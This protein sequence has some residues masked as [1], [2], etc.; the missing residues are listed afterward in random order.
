LAFFYD[1]KLVDISIRGIALL[2]NTIV[3][4]LVYVHHH[5]QLCGVIYSSITLAWL[6][7]TSNFDC[8]TGSLFHL[9]SICWLLLSAHQLFVESPKAAPMA[10]E[11]QWSEAAPTS[12]M[13][14]QSVPASTTDLAIIEQPVSAPAMS[15]AAAL[16]GK[17]VIDDKPF[18]SP[19]IKG[20]ALSI[21]ICQEEYRK[22]VEDCRKVLRARLTLNKGDKPY[23]ARDL[24]IK[25]DKTWKTMAGWK[26]VPLGKGYYDFH[27]DSAE[28][29]KKIWATGTVNLKPGLLRFSQ[30]TKDFKL[31][32]QK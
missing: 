7:H 27:F 28:D 19:C 26:M 24:S 10:Y 9:F 6:N 5:H 2:A 31:L 3:G 11:C 20:G 14:H 23:S 15:F 8:S 25:I 16:A 21:K 13:V 18:P 32:T 1:S 12:A 4:E 29:L 17:T 30:W 22:G